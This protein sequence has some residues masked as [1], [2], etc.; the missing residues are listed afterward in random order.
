MI[1]DDGDEEDDK[2]ED[3][4]MLFI[5]LILLLLLLYLL[6]LL[7]L[8]LLFCYHDR[9]IVIWDSVTLIFLANI[10]MACGCPSCVCLLKYTSKWPFSLE[11]LLCKGNSDLR[12]LI[13][14]RLLSYYLFILNRNTSIVCPDMFAHCF[15]CTVF[16]LRAGNSAHGGP[17]R[18]S[19][20]RSSVRC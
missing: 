10:G 9:M 11:I 12:H 20:S 4:E 1:C 16:F 17:M 5:L 6:L 13:F 2:N 18:S 8:S 7:L 3:D 19:L 14:V 15:L